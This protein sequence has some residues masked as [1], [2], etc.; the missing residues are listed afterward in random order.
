MKKRIVDFVLV[1]SL[2]VTVFSVN[3]FA[4]DSTS[5]K[6]KVDYQKALEIF[7][8]SLENKIP[9]IVEGSIYNVILLKNYYPN[10]DYSNVIDKLNKISEEYPVASIRYKAHLASMYLSMSNGIEVHPQRNVYTHEYLFKQIAD[11][12][13]TKL[14]VAN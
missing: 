14:L 2:A 4:K 10:A 12:L 1:F 11:Q 7:Q 8:S 9:G 13:E 5:A 6:T 3:V